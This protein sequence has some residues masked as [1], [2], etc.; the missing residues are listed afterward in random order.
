MKV[1]PLYVILH[2]LCFSDLSY[3]PLWSILNDSHHEENPGSFYGTS[4]GVQ[5]VCHR[6]P[7]FS[8]RSYLQ[9]GCCSP[10][11]CRCLPLEKQWTVPALCSRAEAS[12]AEAGQSSEYHACGTKGKP[13]AFLQRTHTCC[14]PFSAFSQISVSPHFPWISSKSWGSSNTCRYCCA[15]SGMQ[16]A[17]L[18]SFCQWV[19]EHLHFLAITRRDFTEK[20]SIIQDYSV[21]LIIIQILFLGSFASSQACTGAWLT[22]NH[23]FSLFFTTE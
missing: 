10:N 8:A 23:K 12:R 13:A 20:T 16:L 3:P 6:F 5:I 14:L 2:F 19:R 4:T 7:S 11:I 21:A 22:L 9:A 18:A 1:A 17:W 15:L